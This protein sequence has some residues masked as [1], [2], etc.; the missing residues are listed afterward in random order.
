MPQPYDVLTEEEGGDAEVGGSRA[1]EKPKQ[2][3]GCGKGA[4]QFEHQDFESW[5]PEEKLQWKEGRLTA[6]WGVGQVSIRLPVR[7][8]LQMIAIVYGFLPFVVPAWWLCWVVT[9]WSRNGVPEF[10]PAYGLC[11]AAGFALI[12]E[13]LTKK[14]C[15]KVLPPVITSRPP[16]AVCNHP[17]MPSGHVMNAYTLM[18]WTLIEVLYDY[19]VHVDFLTIIF[20]VMGPVPWAR[21]YNKDHTPLQVKVSMSFALIMGIA[22]W[23]IRVTYFPGQRGMWPWDWQGYFMQPASYVRVGANNTIVV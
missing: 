10:Y 9:S 5:T 4:G 12:N 6:K 18:V 16:E 14:M 19:S 20:I 8:P 17:G 11:I 7:D 15:R 22:A 2:W 23:W 21:V 1:R 3:P 13:T